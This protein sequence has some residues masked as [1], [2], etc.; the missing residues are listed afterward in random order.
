ME[1]YRQF[2]VRRFQ[3]LMATRVDMAALWD[4][5]SCGLVEVYRR[6]RVQTGGRGGAA[7][8]RAAIFACLSDVV[9]QLLSPFLLLQYT[10]SQ[11][12]LTLL[13]CFRYSQTVLMHMYCVC[14]I[15]VYVSVAAWCKAWVLSSKC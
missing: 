10:L 1:L 13:F 7:C 8:Q 2:P 11:K 12:S 3:V 9:V 4:A 14:L 5:A 6:I 15:D